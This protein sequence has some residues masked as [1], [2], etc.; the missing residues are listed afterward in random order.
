MR[1]PV[2]HVTPA[3]VITLDCRTGWN[4]ELSPVRNSQEGMRGRWRGI[5]AGPLGHDVPRGAGTIDAAPIGGI[6]AMRHPR[7]GAVLP[8][9]L[10]ALTSTIAPPGLGVQTTRAAAGGTDCALPH[11]TGP[12][13]TCDAY[14]NGHLVGTIS[15]DQ[16]NPKPGD[17]V[18]IAVRVEYPPVQRLIWE[19]DP[20]DA[21]PHPVFNTTGTWNVVLRF[22]GGRLTG[23]G[24]PSNAVVTSSSA[25]QSTIIW[26]FSDDGC[27]RAGAA[28]DNNLPLCGI[29]PGSELWAEFTVLRH[30]EIPATWFEPITQAEAPFVGAR[31][32]A[33]WF[34]AGTPELGPDPSCDGCVTN[35]GYTPFRRPSPQET[36]RFWPQPGDPR[37]QVYLLDPSVSGTI[38]DASGRPLS[39]RGV[40]IYERAGATDSPCTADP[41][42]SPLTVPRTGP[43][44]SYK[45]F[46]DDPADYEACPD[47]SYGMVPVYRDVSNE[48]V[49]DAIAN[50]EFD[51]Y[52]L[53]GYVRGND[54]EGVANA[55][56]TI[57][58]DPPAAANP[59]RSVT[60]DGTGFYETWLKRG[61]YRVRASADIEDCP[62][63]S[64]DCTIRHVD[65]R[66]ES[67]TADLS[68]GDATADFEL[69]DNQPPVA[70][71][72]ATQQGDDLLHWRFDGSGSSDPDGQVT[73][74]RWAVGN[75][76]HPAEVLD[77]E[78]VEF[79]FPAFETFTVT[80]VV[81]DDR[82]R[83]NSTEQ[84]VDVAG[85]R[86]EAS[87]TSIEPARFKVNNLVA[88]SAGLSNTGLVTLDD[89]TPA[90][91][92][93][94]PSGVLTVPPSASMGS[95][96]PGS[97]LQLHYTFTPTEPGL[98]TIT[99]SGTGTYNGATVPA[100]EVSATHEAGV[101]EQK[102]A[103]YKVGVD[104]PIDT[105]SAVRSGA[106]YDI[107]VGEM[108]QYRGTGWDPEGGPIEVRM[109]GHGAGQD[110]VQTFA[111]AE[112]FEAAFTV[113]FPIL[114]RP[115]V[116]PDCANELVA[117][118]DG[119]Q[120]R[121]HIDG[122]HADLVAYAYHVNR[123]TGGFAVSNSWECVGW[124]AEF[125]DPAAVLVVQD[126]GGDGRFYRG[127]YPG[128]FGEPPFPGYEG[129]WIIAPGFGVDV[130]G[131]F[132]DIEFVANYPEHIL[133]RGLPVQDGGVGRVYGP[134]RQRPDGRVSWA[135]AKVI[136]GGD[137]RSALLGTPADAGSAHLDANIDG[138]NPG[139][140]L[141]IN[142]GGPNQ[143][144]VEY[145]QH[146]SIVVAAP[147]RFAHPAGEQIVVLAPGAPGTCDLEAT[148]AR[149]HRLTAT[150]RC[151]DDG[152]RRYSLMQAPSH[153][154][155]EL[156]SDGSFVYTP[157][158]GYAGP[159]L[160][161]FRSVHVVSTATS[162]VGDSGPLTFRITV[163]NATP[164]CQ[165]LSATVI[166]GQTA[167]I[168][169]GCIDAD[170]DTMTVSI[171]S[172]P[173]TGSASVVGGMIRFTALAAPFV[174]TVTF[175]YAATDG[176]ATSD[177]AIVTV[178]VTGN[179]TL[180]VRIAMIRPEAR[181]AGPLLAAL[182]SLTP[183]R[184]A[185]LQCGQDVTVTVGSL[186]ET[187]PGA[188]FR[189]I[190]GVCTYVRPRSGRGFIANVAFYP[191]TG[192][193]ALGGI[194]PTPSAADL[195]SAV[196]FRLTIGGSTGAESL[197]FVRRGEAWW[198]LV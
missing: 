77:G 5:G 98:Y 4:R 154:T 96:D 57:D 15:V 157:A 187:V 86:L 188:T 184:G 148:T 112:T 79:D 61:T 198:Y 56:I 3:T 139:D 17:T 12:G 161:T 151:P 60:T 174:D 74:W 65:G 41:R 48:F 47:D 146:G 167:E 191:K 149:G 183:P 2:A 23:W 160:F 137:A 193:W 25:A 93:E 20:L 99:F 127:S 90:V 83:T 36:I 116:N 43:D 126:A 37:T 8:A 70:S 27:V 62:P 129:L 95:L 69:G 119:V 196:P 80:L 144:L 166:A 143:E 72:M 165:A 181:R 164:S 18:R 38:R 124:R 28:M 145:S 29:Q 31:T 9:L 176:L 107:S 156:A 150:T 66:P 175:T 40:L 87:F 147:L 54:G 152:D 178:R 89:V 52:R 170:G 46:V 94:G 6:I 159:D 133:V 53:S 34:S 39:D 162:L 76:D 182:G 55:E 109:P 117:T 192:A 13:S 59:S 91:S 1:V 100:P 130:Y 163:T 106:A 51:G 42:P 73:T 64:G 110:Y 103:V 158:A 186:S 104:T 35:L 50:F 88:L 190:H 173:T 140:R 123:V 14:W 122:P 7:L 168:A 114:T 22:P 121:F 136:L 132:G 49:P 33:A 169:P 84:Q 108:L 155:L 195:A 105:S 135:A 141:R 171:S 82:G 128:T 32:A 75:A 81:T 172:V 58:A 85:A 45:A 101:F 138:L 16:A 78:V 102:L 26:A 44:G 179:A 113:D 63:D 71:F 19:Y 189:S 92:I 118:Q 11:A 153:G 24:G 177:P 185:G 180:S 30:D 97:G 120:R 131:V 21:I 115:S 111:P 68:T 125:K 134:W 194:G 197:S 142:G 67:R 10:L